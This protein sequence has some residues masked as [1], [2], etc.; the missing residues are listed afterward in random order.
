[1]QESRFWQQSV[2]IILIALGVALL[3]DALD[4]LDVSAGDVVLVLLALVAIPVGLSMF[5]RA[6]HPM[7][8]VF[9]DRFFGRLYVGEGWRAD[10]ATL[11]TG[12]GE[13]V[14]DLTRADVPEGEHAIDAQGLVGGLEVIVPRDL[15]LSVDAEVILGAIHVLGRSAD[16]LA[17]VLTFTSPDYATASRKVRLNAELAIGELQVHY[18]LPGQES[19]SAGR[20]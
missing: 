13:L 11:R 3:L 18:P 10:A 20:P 19:A 2:A 4:V 16:G 1:M 12:F 7:H 14:L 9:H 8:G 5:R 17:R 6:R 15:A